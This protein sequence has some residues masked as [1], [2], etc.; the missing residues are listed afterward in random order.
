MIRVVIIDDEVHCTEGLSLQ[1]RDIGIPVEILAAYNR[2][3]QAIDFLNENSFDILFLDIEMPRM[4]GFDLLNSINQLN[5]D[6]IFTTAYNQFAIRAFRYS[7]CDYLLKPIT[8]E[9]LLQ[10]I[11]RWKS[12]QNHI[13]NS[14]VRMAMEMMQ[15]PDQSAK[16]IAVPTSE[17]L[18]FLQIDQIIHCDADSNYT[19]V[20]SIENDKILISRTLKEVES[21]LGDRGFIRVHHS[22]LINP[23]YVRKFVRTDGG[24]LVMQDGTQIPVSR[25]KKDQLLNYFKVIQRK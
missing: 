1:L 9:D 17:G 7:A 21:L 5:F 14:Q 16:K 15:Q 3:E 4:N 13:L 19:L 22:H 25:S 18:A 23:A 20:S 11:L 24:Y 12:K 8:D 2:P 6:V 10:S